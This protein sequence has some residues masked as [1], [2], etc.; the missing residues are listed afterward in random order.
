MNFLDVRDQR[1][2]FSYY[3]RQLEQYA[4]HLGTS[5]REYQNLLKIGQMAGF[6]FLEKGNHVI[7]SSGKMEL[8]K[9][10]KEI[11]EAV[12]SI[13]T[14]QKTK[15]WYQGRLQEELKGK[16]REEQEKIISEEAEH[17]SNIKYTMEHLAR[18]VYNWEKEHETI[19]SDYIITE[20][21]DNY[22]EAWGYTKEQFEKWVDRINK[23]MEDGGTEKKKNYE[24]LT[25]ELYNDTYGLTPD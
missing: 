24:E 7:A 23:E 18:E 20:F 10:N 1:N 12:K 13:P 4:K 3:N 22:H 17:I 9:M 15:E 14:W 5:S 2:A 16:K 25:G 6:T 19:E 8:E 21:R 11:I